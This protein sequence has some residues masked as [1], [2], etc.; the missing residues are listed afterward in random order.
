MN[1][2]VFISYSSADTQVANAICTALEKR[3]LPCW[4][5][6]RDVGPGE[7]FQAAI[8]RAIRAARVMVLVFS[9]NANNSDEI[10]KELVLASQND[11]VIIPARVENVA[12]NDSLAYQFATR[13]WVNLF[14]NWENEIER[15]SLWVLRIVSSETAQTSLSG[16]QSPALTRGAMPAP[17]PMLVLQQNALLINPLH[18]FVGTIMLIIGVC[19]MIKLGPE[20]AGRPV[21]TTCLCNPT[22]DASFNAFSGGCAMPWLD[23]LTGKCTTYYSWFI[24][25]YY[26]FI[27][28]IVA[29][30]IAAP[31]FTGLGSLWRKAWA[32]FAGVGFCIAGFAFAVYLMF[33][34]G[35]DSDFAPDGFVWWLSAFVFGPFFLWFGVF[36]L[37]VCAAI[38]ILF[39]KERVG[40]RAARYIGPLQ[41]S[42][43][44]AATI[45]VLCAL[46]IGLIKSTPAWTAA[47]VVLESLVFV[48]SF[49]RFRR[50]FGSSGS[51]QPSSAN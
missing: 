16:A 7:D 8:V 33:G 49:I 31:I 48:W 28:P 12:P 36:L 40:P 35:A 1:A 44:F 46:A 43:V 21:V 32:R 13:Q 4:L 15:L 10:K 24:S 50:E 23:R 11:V 47:L 19:L 26:W 5:A 2:K 39:W 29:A 3:G 17:S 34:V 41:R 6:S 22:D 51:A 37:T 20:L 42:S 30:I 38:Y 27:L 18:H 9:Q 45:L 14:E 25:T